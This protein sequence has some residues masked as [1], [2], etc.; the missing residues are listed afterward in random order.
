MSPSITAY[1]TKHTVWN[2]KHNSRITTLLF[3]VLFP[4]DKRQFPWILIYY[5]MHHIVVTTE[6]VHGLNGTPFKYNTVTSVTDYLNTDIFHGFSSWCSLCTLWHVPLFSSSSLLTA[7]FKH[8]S[9]CWHTS[10]LIIFNI[11]LHKWMTSFNNA[12][13]P[14]RWLLKY[15]E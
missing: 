5:N 11:L 3:G 4:G 7:Q 9:S 8:K 12:A 14:L 15:S 1:H 13:M 2:V 6:V 10:Q